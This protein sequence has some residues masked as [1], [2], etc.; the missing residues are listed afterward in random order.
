[1][2]LIATAGKRVIIFS[3]GF[4]SRDISKLQIQNEGLRADALWN[5]S[6]KHNCKVTHNT[7]HNFPSSSTENEMDKTC[8]VQQEIH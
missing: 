3:C 6:Q 1:M 8:E 5:Q 7:L 4:A 2:K